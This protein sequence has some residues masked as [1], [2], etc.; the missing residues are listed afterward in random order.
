MKSETDSLVFIPINATAMRQVIPVITRS[1]VYLRVPIS[2]RLAKKIGKVK[3][4]AK[5]ES[6]PVIREGD[7]CFRTLSLTNRTSNANKK[8]G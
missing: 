5:S 8:A 3:R 6:F 2:R 1:E 7:L 4:P